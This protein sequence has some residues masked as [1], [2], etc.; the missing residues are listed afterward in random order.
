M[1]PTDFGERLD[2]ALEEQ[3]AS[4]RSFVQRRST[5]A[6]DIDELEDHLRDQVADLEATGLAPDE[7]FLVAV[8]RLGTLHDLS[9]EFAREHSDRLWKQLVLVDDDAG[10][11]SSSRGLL[12]ALAV[13][14]GAGLAMLA[15]RLFGLDLETDGGFYARNLALLVLPFLAGWFAWRRRLGTTAGLA[16]VGIFAVAAVVANVYPFT[17]PHQTEGL[18]AIHLPVLLW[19]VVGVAYTG[20]DWRSSARRMD[21][22]RFTGE[23]AIYYALI[24]FGGGVLVALTV[25]AFSS[26]GLDAEDVVFG[27]LLP[28]AAAGAVIVAAWLVEA[29]HSVI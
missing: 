10:P 23:W 6:P 7:A 2:P 20:G 18:V 24:A 16:V 5:V 14:V 4:W 8:K 9:R 11:S 29:K 22:L 28:S 25:G 3:I 21:F 26:I 13:A 12:A 15:P 19:L 1:T 17:E 27:W